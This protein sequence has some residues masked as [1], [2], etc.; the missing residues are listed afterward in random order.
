MMIDTK[1]LEKLISRSTE[2]NAEIKVR[3][4]MGDFITANMERCKADRNLCE[5]QAWIDALKEVTNELNVLVEECREL[6][7]QIKRM[8]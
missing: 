8:V 2:V 7:R 6:D 3:V 1:K 5:W 4:T